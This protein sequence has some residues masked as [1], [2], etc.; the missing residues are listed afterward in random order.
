MTRIN[1]K[2]KKAAAFVFCLFAILLVSACGTSA[3]T[4]KPT[5]NPSE[6][7]TAKGSAQNTSSSG[8]FKVPDFRESVFDETKAEG[9]EEVKVDI[10]SADKGYFGVWTDSD[11]RLKLQVVKEGAD[12][13]IYD[14]VPK[15]TDIF[16]F[17]SGDGTYTI[18]IM[19][20]IEDS[21]YFELYSVA[22]EV[23]LKDEFAPFLVACQYSDYEKTSKCVTQA[24]DFAKKAADEQAFIKNVYEYV[25]A[26][27]KYDTEKAKNIQSGYIPDPDDTLKTK[28]GICFDYASLTAAMLRSQGIPTKIIFGYVA[29]DD[30]YHAWNMFYTESTGWTLVEFKVD[31]KKWNRV[32]LTFLANGANAKFIGDGSNYTDVYQF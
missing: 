7:T 10:S 5:G 30:I 17:Q 11:A 32:D 23:K 2:I 15:E 14:L 29:P 25:C 8:K 21:K 28:K 18:K 12:T 16:P 26:N 1:K 6:Q 20:N 22:A 13:Y 24:A 9:N 19:K 4:E 27:V 3:Q 31:P